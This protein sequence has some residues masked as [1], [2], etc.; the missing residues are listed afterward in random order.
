LDQAERIEEITKG[1]NDVTVG[2]SPTIHQQEKQ[3][4]KYDF[5][6]RTNLRK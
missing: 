6:I 3:G 1:Q 5:Y 4:V 2:T